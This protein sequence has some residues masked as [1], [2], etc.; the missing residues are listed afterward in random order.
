MRGTPSMTRDRLVVARTS[1]ARGRSLVY[2]Q[3]DPLDARHA[4]R[5]G[6]RVTGKV[7]L[8]D[9]GDPIGAYLRIPLS[10]PHPTQS[11][12][13]IELTRRLL[14]AIT[15]AL[16]SVGLVAGIALGAHNGNNRAELNGTGDPNATGIAIV[17]YSEGRGTFNGNITVSNLEPGE[18]YSFFVRGAGGEQLIC[19]GTASAGGTFTCSAQKLTLAG[20]TMAVVRDS[21]GTEVASGLFERRGNCRDPEQ[22]GS[23][24]QAQRP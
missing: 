8:S 22:G 6:R 3:P 21:S 12:E 2:T 7:S 20:F 13:H 14:G 11:K 19:E 9:V 17:N 15:I 10:Q 23:L 1:G 4:L 18:A 5:S 16:L 24:C